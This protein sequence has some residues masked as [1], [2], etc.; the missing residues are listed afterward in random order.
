MNFSTEDRNANSCRPDYSNPS[1]RGFFVFRVGTPVSFLYK[2]GLNSPWTRQKRSLSVRTVQCGPIDS[3]CNR[4]PSRNTTSSGTRSQTIRTAAPMRSSTPPGVLEA[5]APLRRSLLRVDVEPAHPLRAWVQE[6][7]QHAMRIDLPAH[8]L[9]RSSF[10]P[11]PTMLT[12]LEPRSTRPPTRRHRGTSVGADPI[13]R[14]PADYISEVSNMTA[15]LLL[16]EI[17]S[18]RRVINKS[19]IAC[20]NDSRL[21]CQ[22]ETPQMLRNG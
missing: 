6:R 19:T 13:A 14:S 2:R 7:R 4:V 22:Q 17:G 10:E 8:S 3:P 11:H 15:P 9:I 1:L 16:V 12:P 18:E 21:C 5:G 20:S